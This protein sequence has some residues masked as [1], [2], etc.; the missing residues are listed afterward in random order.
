VCLIGW[1][2]QP[3]IQFVCD[4]AWSDPKWGT[5]DERSTDDEAVHVADND[6][7][8]TFERDKVTCPA[9][10]AKMTS[11]FVPTPSTT[12]GVHLIDDAFFDALD[13]GDIIIGRPPKK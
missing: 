9:C 6:R 4:G 5:D 11:T 8:Y 12:P 13:A 7:L 1:A 10:Q 3:N 2:S